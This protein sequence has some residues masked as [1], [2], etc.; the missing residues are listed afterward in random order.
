MRIAEPVR[1]NAAATSTEG[2][3]DLRWRGGF[4]DDASPTR[5]GLNGNSHT[6]ELTADE[7]RLLD[8]VGEAL[9][10]LGRVKRVALGVQEKADFVQA[11]RKRGRW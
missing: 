10:R 5:E 11:W 3:E 9:A 6:G 2:A 7:K 1:N 8:R 4:V